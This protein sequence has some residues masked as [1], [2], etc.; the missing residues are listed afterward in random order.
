MVTEELSLEN[1]LV[2]AFKKTIR[3]YLD[4]VW[5]QLGAKTKSLVQDLMILRTLL[6]YLIHYDCVTFLSLL[7]S[8]RSSQKTLEVTLGVLPDLWRLH[9][10]TEVLDWSC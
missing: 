4:L 1:S 10:G 9:R 3:H 7:E 5:H 2:N 6:L 8:L